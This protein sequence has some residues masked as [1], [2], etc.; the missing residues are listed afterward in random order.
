MSRDFLS[1][2]DTTPTILRTGAPKAITIRGSGAW[3]AGVA[4]GRHMLALYANIA[5]PE[6][7]TAEREAVARGGVRT[8]YEQRRPGVEPDITGLNGPWAVPRFTR[9]KLLISHCW[10]HTVDM[11][12]WAFMVQVWAFHEDGREWKG[13]PLV[14]GTREIKIIG[15]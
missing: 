2:K 5:L 15:A 8:W 12:M 13:V 1:L 7:G 14:L 6:P 3:R 11:D 4:R 10:P 9:Q